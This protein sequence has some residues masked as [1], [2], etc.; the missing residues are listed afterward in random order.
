MPLDRSHGSS[1]AN[2][3]SARRTEAAGIGLDPD[4]ETIIARFEDATAGAGDPGQ[5]AGLRLALILWARLTSLLTFRMA[6]GRDLPY[7]MGKAAQ[8]GKRPDLLRAISSGAPP[9]DAAVRAIAEGM[10]SETRILFETLGTAAGLER[11]GERKHIDQALRAAHRVEQDAHRWGHPGTHLVDVA[12]AWRERWEQANGVHA[13]P[14]RAC[15]RAA[16]RLLRQRTGHLNARVRYVLDPSCG[17]G[18]LLEAVKQHVYAYPG[19]RANARRLH[20][21]GQEKRLEHYVS[22]AVQTLLRGAG[23][24]RMRDWA[25]E[26]AYA[27]HSYDYVIC[28]VRC[29]TAQNEAA[30]AAHALAR[31]HA[32]P[33]ATGGQR[34]PGRPSRNGRAVLIERA[35]AH[36][37]THSAQTQATATE[38]VDDNTFINVYEPAR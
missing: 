20:S 31:L 37:T 10:T 4:G 18:T 11:I 13:L 32:E 5:V 28:D 15:A 7:W 16:E 14:E 35:P 36:G 22:A 1:K 24:R 9:G 2:A 33:P 6:Q 19:H 21:H 3:G 17:N 30:L 29:D 23:I 25:T 34:P 26:D 27:S 8:I 12:R 38:K